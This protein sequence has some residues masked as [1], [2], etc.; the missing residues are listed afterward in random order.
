[1]WHATSAAVS[2]LSRLSP[3][4]MG[5]KPCLML[6]ATSSSLKSPSGPISISVLVF[7]SQI[8]VRGSLG[9]S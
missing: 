7:F 3:S 6:F 8:C 9:V 1:M 5:L 2:V 4:D